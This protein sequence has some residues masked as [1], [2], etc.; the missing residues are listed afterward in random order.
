MVTHHSPA[1]AIARTFRLFIKSAPVNFYNSVEAIPFL[2]GIVNVRNDLP[3]LVHL[4][5]WKPASPLEALT[6]FTKEYDDV[7]SVDHFLI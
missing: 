3:Q 6:Y 1:D 7:G 4:L 5:A 2:A